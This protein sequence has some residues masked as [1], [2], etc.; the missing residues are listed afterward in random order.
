MSVIFLY[1]GQV[2]ETNQIQ[3]QIKLLDF[4]FRTTR[5]NRHIINHCYTAGLSN[6]FKWKAKRIIVSRYLISRHIFFNAVPIVAKSKLFQQGPQI[7]WRA[8]LK[9][10][11][12]WRRLY[13][14]L[15]RQ[16]A[17]QWA[18]GCDVAYSP[19]LHH[20]IPCYGGE[21][22]WQERVLNKSTKQQPRNQQTNGCQLISI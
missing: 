17:V 12:S 1:S 13:I 22:E 2:P 9:S 10:F 15:N 21:D 5:E 18:C 20:V 8:T 16:W 3:E 7:K 19:L 4:T 6:H 14:P 11:E